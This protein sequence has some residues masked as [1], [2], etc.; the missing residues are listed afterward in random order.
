MSVQSVSLQN[1][2]GT[3]S[4][5]P[6]MST[7]QYGI[8]SLPVADK[9]THV[10]V[11]SLLT[12]RHLSQRRS[13][14]PARKL[15][16][17]VPFYCDDEE[18]LGTKMADTLFIIPR[19]N[20]RAL[21]I[22]Q[23]VKEDHS[24]GATVSEHE[25]EVEALMPKLKQENYYTE[26]PVQELV[27]KERAEPGFCQHVKDFVVGRHG[28]GSIMFVGETDVRKLDLE[29]IVQ[30]DARE[31]TVYTDASKKPPVGEGLNKPAVVTL[32]NIKCFDKKTGQ[33]ITKGAKMEKYK[34]LL[35]KKVREQGAEFVSYNPLKGEWRFR[36]EH[37]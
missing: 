33:Q 4:L 3:P 37:F 7:V 2:F 20:P 6:H 27:A 31:V 11:T 29:S 13:R 8:S 26:P 36:V 18:S 15:H 28:F 22:C 17:S 9:P 35:V 34:D 21:L 12:T 32:L 25:S 1:P 24:K 30:F 16:P 23:N 5:L 19:E 14:L 10:R